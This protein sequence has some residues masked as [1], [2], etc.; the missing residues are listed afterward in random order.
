LKGVEKVSDDTE[1]DS[2]ARSGTPWISSGIQYARRMMRDFRPRFNPHLFIALFTVALA[3]FLHERG[4]DALL[5]LAIATGFLL[6]IYFIPAQERVE[7]NETPAPV[8]IAQPRDRSFLR[9]IIKGMPEAAILVN[10]D[11]LIVYHNERALT[12]CTMLKRGR[13]ISTCIRNPNFLDAVTLAPGAKAPQIVFFNQRVPVEQKIEATV[14]AIRKNDNLSDSLAYILVTLRDLSEQE[15]LARMRADFIANASHELRTPLASLQGFI[16]TLQGPARNDNEARDRFLNIMAEQSKRM[17]RLIDD[18]LSLSRV[19]M[20]AHLPPVDKIDLSEV[21]HHVIDTLEPLA[22]DRSIALNYQTPNTPF[23]VR[24]DRDE[25]VQVFQN[26]VHNAIKYG[27]EGGHVSVR[28]ESTS[29]PHD[30]NP[31]VTVHVTDDG[32]GIAPEH[33]PRLV[34]RFYRVDVSDSRQKGGTGLG[35]AIVKHV[36]A[37]HRGELKIASSPGNGATFSADLPLV[38][39]Q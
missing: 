18:L 33:L 15:S 7:T 37:R 30:K 1:K 5:T 17:T 22:T 3:L 28:F 8:K 10:I 19:E 20:K 27:H 38:A 13:H 31:R 4:A 23:D 24:G 6:L 29:S 16:E 36:L 21:V 14:A 32:P 9:E 34:E 25:L 26:L 11:G 35:L 2:I 12:Y 39:N